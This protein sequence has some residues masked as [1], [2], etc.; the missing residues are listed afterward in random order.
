[1][2]ASSVYLHLSDRTVKVSFI[3][4]EELMVASIV[5]FLLL[6]R[7][8]VGKNLFCSFCD[9][10]VSND[11]TNTKYKSCT[12][13]RVVD[14]RLSIGRSKIFTALDQ[15]SEFFLCLKMRKS[16]RECDRY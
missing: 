13:V 6:G 1:M 4:V 8:E 14:S 15:N 3:F 9:R 10:I 11:S 5:L 12:L 2:M 16:K 7:I